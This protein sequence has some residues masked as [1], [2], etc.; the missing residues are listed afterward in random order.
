M[1][2]QYYESELNPQKGGGEILR[3]KLQ[4]M[5]IACEQVAK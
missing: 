4:N 1:D 3:E 2:R 5:E